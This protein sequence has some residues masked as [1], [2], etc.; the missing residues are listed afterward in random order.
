MLKG[1]LLMPQFNERLKL[2]RREAGLSQQEFASQ[3]GI[4]K[5][6][7]NMYE[8][9]EREPN[10]ETQEAIADYFNVD[11]DFL[12][13]RSEHR[14]KSAWLEELDRTVDLK[15]LKNDVSNAENLMERIVKEYGEKVWDDL[16]LYLQLDIEDRAEIRGAMKQLLRSDKYSIQKESKNA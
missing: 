6:S 14:N 4:S 12:F 15:K 13:G 16:N 1:V 3:I 8:R 7:V 5:S 2:L 11:L 9:G 10:L